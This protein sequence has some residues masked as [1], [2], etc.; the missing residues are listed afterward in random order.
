[1][2]EIWMLTTSFVSAT[3]DK[4]K[5]L[6]LYLASWTVD[7]ILALLFL[8]SLFLEWKQNMI[9]LLQVISQ[10]HRI[11]RVLSEDVEDLV[12]CLLHE[13]HLGCAD[14]DSTLQTTQLATL[15]PAFQATL[16]AAL[17]PALQ[18]TLL[19]PVQICPVKAVCIAFA[20][21][22]FQEG[23]KE[24]YMDGMGVLSFLSVGEAI[25]NVKTHH[26]RFPL[27]PS[28]RLCVSGEQWSLL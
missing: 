21:F 17:V 4:D 27:L 24:K 26:Y 16:L 11:T 14:W 9:F 18:A 3:E 8:R 13:L 12:C 1:M 19:V 2:A 6:F 20:V 22:D 5:K 10:L 25:C 28:S 23:L 7:V 15:L